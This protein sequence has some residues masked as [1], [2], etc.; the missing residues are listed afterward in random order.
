M[1]MKRLRDLFDITRGNKLDF[2]KMIPVP[3]SRGG[4]NFIGRSSQ[5]HGCSG[6]VAPIDGLEPYDAGLITVALG[7]MKPLSA[8][9]Q[10]EPFYT[11]QNVDVLRPISAMSFAEL[12]YV[13]MCIRAN[14]FR[15]SSHGRE[16]NRTL[17]DL[18]IPER[19]EFPQ[20]TKT[21]DFELSVVS[22][23][24]RSGP[25]SPSLD[26][27]DWRLFPLT[28]LFEIKKGKRL[29]KANRKAGSTPFLSAIVGNNGVSAYIS[30]APQ[31]PGNTIAVNYNGNVGEAFYQPIGFCCSDDV[32][33][34]YPK[35]SLTPAVGVFLVTVIRQER[36]RFNFGRKWH[37]ERMATTAIRLPAQADGNPDWSWMERYVNSLPYSSQL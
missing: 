8:F 30:T 31:H 22:S 32:N 36:F 12:V 21:P 19:K 27:S 17:R 37:L 6:T 33:V 34:L 13:C 16:A 14:R 23:K 35:F 11:A 20:W 3:R 1:L 25:Q 4:I 29:T 24:P 18:L 26:V 2:N 15:Y 5:G 28:D 7:G 10:P 9:V